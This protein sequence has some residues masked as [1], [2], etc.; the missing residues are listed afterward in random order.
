MCNAAKK[1]RKIDGEDVWPHI[2]IRK[3]PGEHTIVC[4]HVLRIHLCYLRL[5]QLGETVL[6]AQDEGILMLC[7]AGAG[8]AYAATVVKHSAPQAR[9][10]AAWRQT[11]TGGWGGGGLMQ[12]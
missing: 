12:R 2:C 5:T 11:Q 4:M 9:C 3:V 6:S 10:W 8:P 7:A 1:S